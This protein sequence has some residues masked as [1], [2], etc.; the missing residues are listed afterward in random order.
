MHL[1]VKLLA[2]VGCLLCCA[3]DLRADA[4]ALPHEA[5]IW[6]RNWNDAVRTSIRENASGFS[7]LVALKTEVSFR[8]QQVQV[9]QVPIDYR[10]LKSATSD[11]G[12]A[13][14]IGAF[15][16]PF[17]NTGEPVSTI[18]RLAKNM[19]AEAKTN[20]VRVSELQ[21][22]FDCAES[23][24]S[25][26]RVWIEKLR[27]EIP[28]TPIVIT[29]LPTWLDAAD[30]KSLAEA[31]NGYI[32]QV[33]SFER[34]KSAQ[35]E[36]T[37]CDP[38]AA[39]RAVQKASAIGIH[40]RVAL[41]TYG[42]I[43]AFSSEGKFLGLSAEGPLQSWPA[44]AQLRH[45]SADE[46]QLA[47]LIREWSAHRPSLMDGV[48]WYRLPIPGDRL[49]W[50]V[51][52][53]RSVMSGK[54]PASNVKV[55]VERSEP[56]LLNVVLEN[57][58]DA[59]AS[60]DQSIVVRWKETRLIASDALRGFEIIDSSAV[61]VQFQRR[62]PPVILKPRESRVIGWLRFSKPTEVQIEIK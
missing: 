25:G 35:Q 57:T 39:R 9:V 16:G 55:S 8:E 5:Y 3:F 30:F 18:M 15:K 26:Y 40:Y 36:F 48:I 1:S 20:D 21:I 59:D 47:S 37:L 27:R 6:Q 24:L 61:S 4:K 45:V 29:V 49:N 22:D 12:L 31:A 53:L 11:F 50:T 32:L 42:Y 56:D 58:G 19:L 14:R 52:T 43:V 41:P 54:I 10:T 38:T 33:H 44:T 62:V 51:S 28:E 46:S 2:A 7:R 13:L 60:I 23:K 17:R 34:P